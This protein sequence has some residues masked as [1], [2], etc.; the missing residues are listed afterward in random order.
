VE[1]IGVCLRAEHIDIY[2]FKLFGM[3]IYIY[4]LS[5]SSF[6]IEY[7]DTNTLFNINMNTKKKCF[8]QLRSIRL[9]RI[10][11]P[12]FINMFFYKRRR[13]L[14]IK[15]IKSTRTLKKKKFKPCIRVITTIHLI[16]MCL[17]HVVEVS[18]VLV[19]NIL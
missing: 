19:N 16:N 7:V 18:I 13:I 8:C 3:F 4:W 9:V 2:I 11:L 15:S 6:C 10:Q 5:K 1:Y 12:N 14:L 17:N